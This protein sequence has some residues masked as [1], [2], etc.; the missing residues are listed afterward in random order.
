[1]I[2]NYYHFWNQ[3]DGV[4]GGINI[5]VLYGKGVFYCYPLT[6]IP[7]L[8]RG[9]DTISLII[10]WGLSIRLLFFGWNI[11]VLCSCDAEMTFKAYYCC[12]ETFR[13]DWFNFIEERSTSSLLSNAPN[14]E[15]LF[16]VRNYSLI[17]V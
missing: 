6:F 12:E 4:S 15:D 1:M 13:F 2:C 11:G 10:F 8:L 16:K 5:W 14:D 7:L 9:E 3:P 17:D